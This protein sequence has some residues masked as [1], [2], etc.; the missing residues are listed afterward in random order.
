MSTTILTVL[1]VESREAYC[2]LERW[3]NDRVK[4]DPE[5]VKKV[6]ISIGP[7]GSYFAR[8]GSTHTAHTLP[9]DLKTA[10]ENSKSSPSVVALGARG[11]WVVLWANDARSWDLRD[12]YPN[13]AASGYLED[14]GNKVVFIALDP[15]IEGNHFLVLEDGMCCCNATMSTVKESELMHKLTYAY[16]QSRAK[17]DGSSFSQTMTLNDVRKK[18]T[19]TP[20]STEQQTRGEALMSMLRGR[21]TA[22]K[23]NDVAFVCA[24]GGS[25]GTLAKAAG[26]PTL[27][28]A[29]VAAS[30]SIGA[31]LSIWYR[32]V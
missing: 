27:R 14:E 1:D 5:K 29:G 2:K 9:K 15:Y 12:A 8:S 24:V 20:D 11:A 31:V 21:Q 30:M 23:H 17:R 19:I 25:A 7:K 16:M 26:L 22:I 18:Y 4:S 10:I 3:L 32:T 6:A 13:L 28:A